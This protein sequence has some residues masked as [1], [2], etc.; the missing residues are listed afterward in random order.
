MA[1]ICFY[2]E[3]EEGG[4]GRVAKLAYLLGRVDPGPGILNISANTNLTPLSYSKVVL[5]GGQLA[6]STAY[7]EPYRAE[8]ERLILGGATKV[9]I[10]KLRKNY[11]PDFR[12]CPKLSW[13]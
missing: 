13:K 10:I 8:V 7:G 4:W 2:S 9:E 5:E 6:V 1:L 11:R 12:G 3:E